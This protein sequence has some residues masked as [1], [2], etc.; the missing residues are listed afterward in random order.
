MFIIGKIRIIAF[1]QPPP[2]DNFDDSPKPIRHPQIS[3]HIC[4]KMRYR[5]SID[6][7]DVWQPSCCPK[8]F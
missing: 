6:N 8:K 5:V 7:A 3:I 2:I 4:E 1:H